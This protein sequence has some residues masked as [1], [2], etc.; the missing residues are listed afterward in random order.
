MVDSIKETV[1]SRYNQEASH[2][3]S[4]CGIV[5]MTY[6]GSTHKKS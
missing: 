6:T 5:R 2:K 3:N 1:F 4:Q